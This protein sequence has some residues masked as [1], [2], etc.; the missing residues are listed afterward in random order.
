M[1]LAIVGAGSTRLPLMLASVAAA[2][3]TCRLDA[4]DL[5]DVRPDRV[6]ALLPVGQALAATCGTLPPVAVAA[7]A[8]Q[9][10]EGADAVVYTIRP[11]FEAGRARDERTCLDLGVL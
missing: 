5:F 11:G 4:V 10:L 6:A 8:E 1:K 7:T 3:R 9:A 2:G